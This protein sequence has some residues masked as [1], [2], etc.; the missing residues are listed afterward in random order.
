MIS[1]IAKFNTLDL[2]YF[3]F[4]TRILS[5]CWFA[6]FL[7]R[8]MIP[9]FFPSYKPSSYTNKIR[10][11]V[12]DSFPLLSFMFF[13]NK[14][15]FSAIPTRFAAS[16]VGLTFPSRFHSLFFSHWYYDGELRWVYVFPVFAFQNLFSLFLT[17]SSGTPPLNLWLFF[18]T[19]P[20]VATTAFSVCCSNTLHISPFWTQSTALRKALDFILFTV[21]FYPDPHRL[22]F[23]LTGSLCTQKVYTPSRA[24]NHVWDSPRS[25]CVWF[26]FPLNNW[27]GLSFGLLFTPRASFC[28]D[29]CCCPRPKFTFKLPHF[30]LLYLAV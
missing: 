17:F 27:L 28:T 20:R 22:C 6:S 18:I 26:S 2:V 4:T 25:I 23:S 15:V 30:F 11:L 13:P 5:H 3:L 12:V 21:C 16:S 14:I 9:M 8:V 24:L 10:Y 1:C 29:L 19:L 7:A